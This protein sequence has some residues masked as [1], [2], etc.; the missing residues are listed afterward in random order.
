MASGKPVVSTTV[1]GIPE[2]VADGETGLL[3]NRDDPSA[4]AEAI[5]RLA[6]DAELR[7]RF[8]AAGRSRLERQFQIAQTIQP[9]LRR[10]ES[11]P[12]AATARP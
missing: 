7:G 9:L 4:L 6:R 2:L 12:T 1:A 10:F 8:G 11:C 3:V 5:L